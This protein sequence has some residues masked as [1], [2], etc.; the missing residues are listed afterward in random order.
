MPTT[1]AYVSH[2]KIVEFNQ[3]IYEVLRIMRTTI[4]NE[5]ILVVLMAS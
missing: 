2:Y 3:L 5:L 4:N 1:M